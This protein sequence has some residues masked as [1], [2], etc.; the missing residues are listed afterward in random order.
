MTA[1]QTAPLPPQIPSQG[2]ARILVNLSH[3]LG[4]K[5]G[6]GLMSLVYLVIATHRLGP[7][8]YGILVLLSAYV[9]LVGVVV[10]FSGFHGVVRYGALA[11]ERGDAAELARIIRFMGVIE[12]SCGAAAVLIAAVAAP[13]VGPRLG[14]SVEAQAFAL[15][16]SLGVLGT[17]RATPPGVL[18]NAGR[19]EFIRR[20]KRIVRQHLPWREVMP[21]MIARLIAHCAFGDERITGQLFVA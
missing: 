7:H 16:F 6:A 20:D 15:P 13:W 21:L 10:A 2:L 18:Q 12:L 3:L 1:P 4:G 9:G 19:F 11:R 17:V 14:W 8:N 5:A